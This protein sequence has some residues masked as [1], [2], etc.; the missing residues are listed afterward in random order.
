M[1]NE[2]KFKNNSGSVYVK[3]YVGNVLAPIFIFIVLISGNL[4]SFFFV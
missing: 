2:P 1:G 4:P 3:A